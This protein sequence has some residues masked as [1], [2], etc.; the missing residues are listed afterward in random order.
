MRGTYGTS[1]VPTGSPR[2]IPARAG[3]ISIALS[4]KG[5]TPV[6]PRTCGEHRKWGRLTRQR[7]GSSPHVRGT[8]KVSAGELGLRRFIPARAGNI[9]P[10][11]PDH[12][13][14]AVHPRTC[15]EHFQCPAK[16]DV[17]TGSS[18][19]VRGTSLRTI[20]TPLNDRFIPARA[21]NMGVL[22]APTLPSTVHPRTCGEHTSR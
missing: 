8:Y 14:K 5:L 3:N 4:T 11:Q 19:H 2:F 12:S 7:D 22:H 17:H 10:K 6:H 1:S 16:G 21:G 20:K 15:G 13:H 9:R 18:P